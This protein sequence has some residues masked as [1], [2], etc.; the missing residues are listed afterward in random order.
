VFEC[1]EYEGRLVCDP[2]CP[3]AFATLKIVPRRLP[4]PMGGNLGLALVV[5]C[6]TIGLEWWLRA[7]RAQPTART[8]VVKSDVRTAPY[9]PEWPGGHVGGRR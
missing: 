6:M 5:E 1:G 9:S 7:S 3:W 4:M 2:L 8:S